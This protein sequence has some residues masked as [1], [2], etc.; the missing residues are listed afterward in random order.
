M[1]TFPLYFL[2]F[3]YG[4][5]LLIFLF[6]SIT[7]IWHIIQTGAL[8]MASFVI[9]VIVALLVIFT[10]LATTYFLQGVNWQEPIVINW[11]SFGFNDLTPNF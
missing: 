3:A 5:F 10:F 1:I 2:F 7:N 8:S 9:T 6:F 4:A 11:N